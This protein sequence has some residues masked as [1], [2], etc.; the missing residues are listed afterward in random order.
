MVKT[1]TS[2]VK[3]GSTILTATETIDQD[4][5]Q[6]GDNVLTKN[7]PVTVAV[8]K[9]VQK[10]KYSKNYTTFADLLRKME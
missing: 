8:A 2:E 10:L 1:V 9:V 3:I 4:F 7:S 5:G 6:N